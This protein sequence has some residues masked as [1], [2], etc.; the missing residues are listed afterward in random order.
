MSLN[1]LT[2]RQPDDWH[3]HL[4]DHHVLHGVV[5]FT[6]KV[7]RRAIVMPNLDPPITSLQAAI[8]YRERILSSLPDGVRFTPLMTAYLTDDLATNVLEE[9]YK[10]GIFTA[11]KLYPAN[12]TTNSSEG[13]SD[14][15][16][17]D[18][19][20][21]TMELLDMPLL[22][23][24]EVTEPQVDIF[25]REEIFIDNHLYPM[26]LRHPGLRVVLEHITTEQSVQFVESSPFKLAATITPH[27]L[28]INRN[29]MFNGGIRSD[30][31][32]LPVAKRERHRLA[33]RK[34]A[35]SGKDCFFIGTDSAPHLRRDKESSCGCAGIFNA[36]Y[37]LESYAEVFDQEGSLE[38]FEAFVSKNGPSFY[39]MPLN[40]SSISLVRRS[41][42][43]PSTIDLS[44]ASGALQQLVP[45]HA[46]EKL[47]WQVE[48][49]S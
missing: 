8:D 22:V 40:E 17:I 1:K 35:T 30:F 43:V 6:A 31:Y 14:L 10:K 19:L 20:L 27:H 15:K 11:A 44:N 49:S 4:R 32:C 39:K 25:D 45:F 3:V 5:G 46:G 41:H 42:V 16:A 33:L 21:E 36:P 38:H 24:G 12:S 26:L 34:A 7:F 37:A 48:H 2:V 23:H 18:T 29:S 13:V 9:G 47:S 28:H